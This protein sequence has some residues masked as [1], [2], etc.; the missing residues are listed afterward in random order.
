MNGGG[1]C[2]RGS[3]GLL[4]ESEPVSQ[5][6]QQV[7]IILDFHEGGRGGE[8][9]VRVSHAEFLWRVEDRPIL[10]LLMPVE[11]VFDGV[12]ESVMVHEG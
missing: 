10:D 9:D 6:G 8:V 12:R 11:D 5:F 3:R 2:G 1:R 7:R 4:F